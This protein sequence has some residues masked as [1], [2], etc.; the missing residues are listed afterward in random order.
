LKEPGHCRQDVSHLFH[1]LEGFSLDDYQPFSDVSVAMERPLA[2]I[3]AALA[4]GLS[5][6]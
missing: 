5:D 3:S 1:D 6:S 2:F 4:D